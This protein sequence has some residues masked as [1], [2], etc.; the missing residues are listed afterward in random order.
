MNTSQRAYAYDK[1]MYS[2]VGECAGPEIPAQTMEELRAL[3]NAYKEGLGEYDCMITYFQDMGNAE[4]VRQNASEEV[5]M[6][7]SEKVLLL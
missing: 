7:L 4:E 5:F 6:P 3:Y 2:F 1:V